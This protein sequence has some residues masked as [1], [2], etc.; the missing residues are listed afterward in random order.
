M[1]RYKIK[2]KENTSENSVADLAGNPQNM[3][4]KITPG[5]QLTYCQMVPQKSVTGLVDLFGLC[6]LDMGQMIFKNNLAP[7]LCITELYV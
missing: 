7:L 2:L 6:D 4:W 5:S 1:I 3:A